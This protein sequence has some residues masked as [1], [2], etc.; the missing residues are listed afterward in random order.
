MRARLAFAFILV[1]SLPIGQLPHSLGVLGRASEDHACEQGSIRCEREGDRD[2]YNTSSAWWDPNWHF[3][4]YV[5]VV[6]EGCNRTDFPVSVV[7]NF[8][9][10]LEP[11]G[12]VDGV[13][14][15]SIRV[16]EYGSAANDTCAIVGTKNSNATCINEEYDVIEVRFM[17][18]GTTARDATRRFYVYF[19]TN[20]FEKPPFEPPIKRFLNGNTKTLVYGVGTMNDWLGDEVDFGLGS[21][22]LSGWLSDATANGIISNFT[23]ANM[24]T[25]ETVSYNISMV[26][27]LTALDYGIFVFDISQNS[28]SQNDSYFYRMTPKAVEGICKFIAEGGKVIIGAHPNEQAED[29]LENNPQMKVYFPFKTEAWNAS[30]YTGH[31]TGQAPSFPYPTS[32]FEL[33]KF[34]TYGMRHQGFGARLALEPA[35]AGE[36]WATD[37]YSNNVTAS[38]GYCIFNCDLF[39]C[40]VEHNDT[41]DYSR[42][43]IDILSTRNVAAPMRTTT[44][45]L[46]YINGVFLKINDEGNLTDTIEIETDPLDACNANLTTF[47]RGALPAN[48]SLDCTL[49]DGGCNLSFYHDSFHFNGE[50]IEFSALTIALPENASDGATFRIEFSARIEGDANFSKITLVIISK[51]DIGCRLSALGTFEYLPGEHAQFYGIINNTGRH[52]SYYKA[53]A[54]GGWNVSAGQGS[55]YVQPGAHAGF[56]VEAYI[57]QDALGGS[58]MEVTL[59]VQADP[60]ADVNATTK[61]MLSVKKVSNISI[62]C[63]SE[64]ITVQ[65]YECAMFSFMVSNHGNGHELVH[66]FVNH[67]PYWE[68]TF[69]PYELSLAV[70]SSV[71]LN[72]TVCAPPNAYYGEVC[73]VEMRALASDASSSDSLEAVAGERAGVELIAS[74]TIVESKPGDVAIFNITVKNAGNRACTFDLASDTLR[75]GGFSS[76]RTR[77][78]LPGDTEQFQG[79]FL[80][81]SDALAGSEVK[82]TAHCIG[83]NASA[84]KTIFVKV[85]HEHAMKYEI[86]SSVELYPGEIANG[87]LAITNEGNSNESVLIVFEPSPWLGGT[88]NYSSEW[89]TTVREFSRS[90]LFASF[91]ASA[92]VMTGVHYVNLTI[93]DH[94]GTSAFRIPVVVKQRYAINVSFRNDTVSSREGKI[95]VF[96]LIVRNSGNGADEINLTPSCK[97]SACSADRTHLELF[98][99]EWA[100]VKLFVRAPSRMR[101]ATVEC[102]AT[103]RGASDSA[104]AMLL[105]EPKHVG[106]DDT[107]CCLGLG[108]IAIATFATIAG[109][110]KRRTMKYEPIEVNK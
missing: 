43:F 71:V 41:Y 62:E 10:Q 29:V 55:I 19:D 78:I 57:P 61:C 20:S 33:T 101:N 69:E 79:E 97:N 92:F 5:E 39:G 72:A 98:N 27:N 2:L 83:I 90:N 84:S 108:I 32:E 38:F 8:S 105:I 95:A 31:V 59:A 52:A 26:E 53:S 93:I 86:P 22:G 14:I 6:S 48:V 46:E 12:V 96:E 49:N 17:L 45:T 94:N 24:P 54:I 58:T 73:A 107:L 15:D 76:V 82:C 7:V 4:L 103:S 34:V 21:I 18:D 47:Y 67:T 110:L 104:S 75:F 68:V 16:V 109:I 60:R 1:L 25:C 80:V 28:D 91:F 44:G 9:S 51:Y 63:F 30:R 64:R 106:A 99:D 81:P 13:D 65:P 85:L 74:P 37:E 87:M 40:Q 35:C 88:I 11:L 70:N 56:L 23:W 77:L 42:F 100:V 102:T 50:G 36:V 89:R 3:R 66:I